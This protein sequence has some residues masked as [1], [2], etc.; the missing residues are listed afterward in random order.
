MKNLESKS[1]KEDVTRNAFKTLEGLHL[2]SLLQNVWAHMNLRDSTLPTDQ[3]YIDALFTE[4]WLT[5]HLVP[6]CVEWGVIASSGA[7]GPPRSCPSALLPSLI[8]GA[9]AVCPSSSGAC[10]VACVVAL[11]VAG[12][13]AW[14]LSVDSDAALQ[15]PEWASFL[16]TVDGSLNAVPLCDT[17]QVLVKEV[18]AENRGLI[19]LDLKKPSA[20][21]SS[22]TLTGAAW[23]ATKGAVQCKQSHTYRV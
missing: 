9:A 23:P 4:Q 7:F 14:R 20:E 3:N 21:H 18:M 17:D 12:V 19:L 11:A 13:V 2:R 10:T 16:S 8:L 1:K 5:F 6:G 15:A 22:A